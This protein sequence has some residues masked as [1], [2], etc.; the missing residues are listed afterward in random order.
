MF[1]CVRRF[2]SF[3][4]GL[5]V[6]DVEELKLVLVLAGGD[7]SQ[8][9]TEVL[10]LEVLLGQVLEVS[11]GEGDLS[12]DDEGVLVLGNSDGL[13]EVSD[14]AINLDVLGEVGLKVVEHENV[15]LDWVLAVNDVLVGGFLSLE[16]F[17]C[18]LN[19]L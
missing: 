7:D 10:L 14:H 1:C 3:G 16:G 19:H 11:L 2:H 6:V 5:V 17:G 15:V 13:A 12:L 18:L 9:L 8:V 4:V